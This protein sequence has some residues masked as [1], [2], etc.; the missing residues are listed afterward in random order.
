MNEVTLQ[1]YQIRYT[2]DETDAQ[3]LVDGEWVDLPELSTPQIDIDQIDLADH[4][5][6]G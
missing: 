6:E 5:N 3:V 2:T 1:G 4:I